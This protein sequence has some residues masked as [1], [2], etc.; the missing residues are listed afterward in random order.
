MGTHMYRY[1]YTRNGKDMCMCIHMDIGMDSGN[2]VPRISAPHRRRQW[3]SFL[4]DSDE[5]RDLK[6]EYRK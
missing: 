5:V 2:L 4:L 6:H 1:I 3:V